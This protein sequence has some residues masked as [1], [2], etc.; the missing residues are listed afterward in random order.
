ME[1]R[2]IY[3]NEARKRREGQV[4]K[5]IE[6]KLKAV[7]EGKGFISVRVD[8]LRCKLCGAE[9]VFGRSLNTDLNWPATNPLAREF[10]RQHENECPDPTEAI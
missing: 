10:A 5:N 8:R 2:V 7:G 6:V 4:L 3:I 1:G 9:F